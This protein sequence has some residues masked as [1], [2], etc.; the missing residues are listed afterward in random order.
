MLAL[1][2]IRIISTALGNH[3][4]NFND[5]LIRQPSSGHIGDNLPNFASKLVKY[6]LSTRYKS[7]LNE[8]QFL[9]EVVIL[10]IYIDDQNQARWTLTHDTIYCR[11]KL[12]IPGSGWRGRSP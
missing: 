10:N 7:K 12:F 4:Y 11:E 3:I 2:L 5:R 6:E 8:L 1:V 9:E